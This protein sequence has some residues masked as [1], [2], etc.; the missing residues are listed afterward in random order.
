MYSFRE[1]T[2]VTDI[3]STKSILTTTTTTTPTPR[4]QTTTPRITT[5][6]KQQ[7]QQRHQYQEQKQQQQR[8]QQQLEH[9][10]NPLIT[11][12]IHVSHFEL[13]YHGLLQ[14]FHFLSSSNR[15]S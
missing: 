6:T 12:Y 7:Q 4:R 3:T 14:L 10:V 2:F 13:F 15:F 8:Q 5:T 11:F 1:S 9:P